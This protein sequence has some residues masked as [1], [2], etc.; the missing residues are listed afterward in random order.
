MN[1]SIDIC[2]LLLPDC[3]GTFLN[4]IYK[5]KLFIRISLK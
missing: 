1:S 4:S 3:S 5:S 2:S